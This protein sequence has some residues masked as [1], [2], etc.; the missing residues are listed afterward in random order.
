MPPIKVAFWNINTGKSSFKDRKETLFDWCSVVTPDLLILEE[1]SKNLGSD[2]PELTG[3]T[4]VNF[5]NTLQKNGKPGTKQIW[6]LRGAG[7]AFEARPL[8]MT[9]ADYASRMTIKVTDGTK[10]SIR[11]IHANATPWGGKDAVKTAIEM[12]TSDPDAVVGG[13]FNCSLATART[14]VSNGVQAVGCNSWQA[15]ALRVS[16]W[17]KEQGK[18]MTPPVPEIHLTTEDCGTLTILPNKKVID[19][20]VG[21]NNCVGQGTWIDILMNFDHAPVVFNIS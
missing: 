12:V 20:V 16:Q 6:A 17:D 5:V 13:D 1:V 18:R 15:N 7:Q 19:Y 21:V 4:P 14:E 11:G 3:L 2:L 9:G 10:L 8:R